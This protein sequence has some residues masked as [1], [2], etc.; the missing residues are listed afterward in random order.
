MQIREF[1]YC[2]CIKEFKFVLQFYAIRTIKNGRN[3]IRRGFSTFWTLTLGEWKLTDVLN[4]Y[5]IK[6]TW[7][8]LL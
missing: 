5:R 8:D 1:E 7:F 6:V 4:C 3:H 2:I